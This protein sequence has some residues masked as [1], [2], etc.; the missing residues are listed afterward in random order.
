MRADLG[1]VPTGPSSTTFTVWAPNATMV[2]VR[3]SS[4][5]VCLTRSTDGY[6]RGSA[7]WGPGALYQYVLDD[8]TALADPASRAQPDGVHGPS[9][10]VDLT[11]SWRDT[12]FRPSPLREWILYELHIGTFTDE[13]TFAGAVGALDDLVELGVTAVEIMPV[14]Q[15]PGR[16]NWGYDGVFP[17]AVQQTYGGPAGL[18][19]FVALNHVLD[20]MRLYK[21]RP[22]QLSLRRSAQIAVGAHRRAI[23]VRGAHAIL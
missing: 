14:A 3:G 16:R 21:S 17:F 15:F 19:E 12:A 11:Y 20:D 8:G 2:E 18:Q 10:V 9:Q 6:H 4:G 23:A 7:P 1:A 13:G 22:E 5:R